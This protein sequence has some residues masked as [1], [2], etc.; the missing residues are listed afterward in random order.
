MQRYAA[1]VELAERER[2]LVTAGRW[3]ELPE[4]HA[5]RAELVATMPALPPAEARAALRR[6]QE[7]QAEVLDVLRRAIGD[8]AAELS[9]LRRA[10]EAAR[11]YA[12]A[13]G[14]RRTLDYAG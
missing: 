10:R 13:R 1:L 9:H 11:G 14:D 6:A 3:D 5:R 8:T 12:P 2:E 7:L 4:L